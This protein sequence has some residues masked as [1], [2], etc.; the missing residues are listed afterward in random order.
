MG[1]H[2]HRLQLICQFLPPG[3]Y[4]ERTIDKSLVNKIQSHFDYFYRHSRLSII[5]KKDKYFSL[6]P[7]DLQKQV[8][9]G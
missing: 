2:I 3:N 7:K 4:T 5:S 1:E 6:M 9:L 8:E